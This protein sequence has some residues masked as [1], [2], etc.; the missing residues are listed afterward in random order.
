[1]RWAAGPAKKRFK[2]LGF[3]QRQIH[4]EEKN[5]KL[6][7]AQNELASLGPNKGV[8]SCSTV[9]SSNRIAQVLGRPF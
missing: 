4:G 1:M 2:R 7:N 3:T 8:K 9:K 5:Q 6:G